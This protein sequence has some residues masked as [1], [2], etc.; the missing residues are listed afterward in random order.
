MIYPQWIKTYLTVI[1]N[2]EGHI[3]SDD[4]I[5]ADLAVLRGAVSI[6]SLHTHNPVKQAAL[7]DRGLIATL[8]KHWRKLIDVIHTHVHGGPE[9]RRG[10]KATNR[11]RAIIQ[12]SRTQKLCL[13]QPSKCL[14]YS[15][16]YI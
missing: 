11:E 7:G 14:N 13:Q 8:H 3:R 16:Y 12:Q 15:T 2:G 10:G 9:R 4:V 1:V 5:E 6:Q